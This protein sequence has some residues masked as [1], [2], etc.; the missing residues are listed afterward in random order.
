LSCQEA[1]GWDPPWATRPSPLLKL[2][3]MY[4]QT[5]FVDFFFQLFFFFST[6][7]GCTFWDGRW[8]E[9][10]VWMKRKSTGGGAHTL[11]H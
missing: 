8:C 10:G 2:V 5:F 7:S 6:T 1:V 11:N 9:W 4:E 3:E